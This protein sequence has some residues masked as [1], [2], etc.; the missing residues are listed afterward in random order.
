[1]YT[2][3]EVDRLLEHADEYMKIAIT[4]G[5]QLGLREQELQHAEFSDIDHDH[6]TFRVRSKPQ[7]KFKVKD[8]E[9]RDVPIP[10]A[11]LAMLD[12]W[13]KTRKHIRISARKQFSNRRWCV[14]QR[15]LIAGIRG[16]A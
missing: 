2:K 8:S 10:S 9:E 12:A 7:Y 1:V 4:M 11:L 6:K 13:C 16:H 15:R 5:L 14:P 3:A